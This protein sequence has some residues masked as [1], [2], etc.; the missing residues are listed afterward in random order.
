[1]VIKRRLFSLLACLLAL[2]ISGTAMAGDVNATGYPVVDEPIT[3]HIAVQRDVS[4]DRKSLNDVAYLQE[5]NE[6]TGVHVIWDEYSGSEYRE[7]VNLMFVSGNLPDAFFGEG[8]N[9]IDI[10]SNLDYFIPMNDLIDQ[11]A[12]N[13]QHCFEKEPAIKKVV[14]STDGNI[15]SL[16]RVR[17]SYFPNTINMMAINKKWL[18]K[19]GLAVPTTLDEFYQ[20]LKAFKENDPN[21][22]GVQDEIPLINVHQMGNT[23]ITEN[24]IYP[25]FGVY[26][27]TSYS[28]LT[29]HLMMR[30]GKTLFTPAQEGYKQALQYLHR[31]YSEGLLDP[32][33]FTSTGDTYNAKMQDKKDIIG[34]FCAWTISNGVGY[35]RMNDFVQLL[36]LAGPEGDKGW[37]VVS[38][39]AIGRNMFAITSKNAYPEAT[40]R[41]IDEF[42]SA[43]TSIQTFYG[44][45]GIMTTK[46]SDG[47]VVASNPPE[48]TTYGTWRWG[49]IP[50]DSACYACFKDFED[51]LTPAKQQGDR[52]VYQDAI[53]PWLQPSDECY[54]NV[55]FTLDQISEL[56]RVVVDL[57]TYVETSLAKFVTNGF[58]DSD[59]EG[60]LQQLSVIGLDKALEIWDAACASY[61]AE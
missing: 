23:N 19:L 34:S 44:P 54:P 49:N 46:N 7:K 28:E 37:S 45:Y 61:N 25:C 22:N 52:A 18:D 36:P 15:Y 60:Y 29:Y 33:L 5:I 40:M 51:F 24:W 32:E 26:D 39:I 12:P 13:I 31:L 17:Q 55:T 3:I 43:D 48:G 57:N 6:R 50:A 59:W 21:G 20:V 35:D 41:W 56:Q 38:D 10:Q 2:V 1:M 14:T 30:D 8:L 11:Y 16:F 4:T 58:T 47:T 53:E 9:D 27:N 42:Y